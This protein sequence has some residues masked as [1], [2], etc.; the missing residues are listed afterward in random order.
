MRIEAK[1]IGPALAASL[2]LG[3][4]PAAA[5]TRSRELRW[6]PAVDVAVTVGGAALWLASELLKDDLAPPRCH[7]CRENAVDACVRGALVWGD[8]AS[9]ERIS[10]LTAFVLVPLA[11][12]ELDALAAAHEAALDNVPED[13]LLVA[14]AGVIAADVTQLTKLLVRRERPFVHALAPEEKVATRAPADNNL[15]FFS[16]HTAETFALAAASGTIGEL[17]GYRWA[18]AAWGVGGA[19]AAFTAY[20][21]IAA[22][23]HW[24][25]DVLVGAIVGAGIGVAVPYLFH[26]AL[27]DS[28]RASASTALRMPAPPAGPS[29]TLAW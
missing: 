3:S 16:G 12:I 5:Q 20:L 22:D 1:I 10:D 18:P 15:S 28:T 24:L 13:T 11:A 14:E 7:W 6:D 4:A 19:L 23:K 21:R 2:L 26:P 8:K 29:M 9:A 17:R 25:T 27:D